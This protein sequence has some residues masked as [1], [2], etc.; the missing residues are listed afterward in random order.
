MTAKPLRRFIALNQTLGWM[1]DSSLPFLQ[2]TLGSAA[3]QISDNAICVNAGLDA[4]TLEAQLEHAAIKM[5]GAGW[6][7]GWRNER[8]TV[9]ASDQAGDL[10]LSQPLFE[11]E[12]AAFRRFGLTSR[13]VHI[14]GYTRSGLW[15]AQR[16]CSKA[17]DPDKLDNLA[18]GGISAGEKAWDCVIRELA[19]EAGIPAQLASRAVSSGSLRTTRAEADGWHDEVIYTYDLLLPEDFGPQNTDGE[20]AGFQHFSFDQIRLILPKMTLDAAAVTQAFLK[21][22]HI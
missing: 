1:E 2:A 21:Q 14:N 9:F 15:I 4:K 19:E 10:D 11:L 7:K 3:M 17:I 20:V 6:I 13:A 8:Y 5:R 12:R 16:A 18:A 22:H